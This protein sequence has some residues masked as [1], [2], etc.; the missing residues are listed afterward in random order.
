MAKV[1]NISNDGGTTW[2]KLPGSQGSFQSD[3]EAIDDTILGQTYASSDVGLVGWSVSSDGI[4]KG[5][6]GYLAEIKEVGTATGMTTEAMSV[7][8]GLTYQI[9]DAAKEIWDRSSGTFEVQDNAVPVADAD[10]LNV[11]Y[12]FGRVTFVAG[13]TPT[14]SITVTGD[15]FPTAAI[16]KANSYS[17]TMT[18]EAIDETDFLTAQG[19]SGT[20]VFSAGLRTVALELGGIWLV[21]ATHNP[22][23]DLK[24]RNE[25]IIEIDPAGDG[26]SIARGFFKLASTG[27]SGAVGALEE[28]SLNFA[29]TVP[30]ETTNPEVE[31]PFG[32][33]HTATT[34]NLAIQ[35]ALTSWLDELNT[36]DCQYL[37]T[38]AEGATPVD[39][40]EGNF[41]VTD[42]S[43]SG[44][45]SNM[46]VFTIE[47][48]GTG[49]FVEV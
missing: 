34:L 32:W 24:N 18:A 21:T 7:V 37:P 2:E 12:L 46:N 40:I 41:V 16:G 48:Q 27:Q 39:G 36:Y 14:G 42:I 10:I 4:F 35:W 9:D 45:V 23:D 1:I 20:R 33:Q 13:Y 8:T 44:G 49:A 19:N 31:F 3:A 15:Y 29:L 28:E 25:I 22:K 47:L 17:M 43:L 30:D 38:G 26:S 5:F 11:D 6:S